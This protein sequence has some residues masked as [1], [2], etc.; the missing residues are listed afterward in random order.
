[1]SRQSHDP[2]CT[3]LCARRRRR[4][5]TEKRVAP[6]PRNPTKYTTHDA[7]RNRG[8]VDVT[9]QCRIATENHWVSR[10]RTAFRLCALG[11][12]VRVRRIQVFSTFNCDKSGIRYM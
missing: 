9:I 1:M 8:N 12:I 5:Q 3:L 2:R 4:R 6:K 11:G 10:Y 7:P